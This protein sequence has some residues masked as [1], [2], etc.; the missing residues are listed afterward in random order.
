MQLGFKFCYDKIE[1]MHMTRRIGMEEFYSIAA[2]VDKTDYSE[3]AFAPETLGRIMHPLCITI[4]VPPKADN[5]LKL[6]AAA[7]FH[8]TSSSESILLAL[9]KVLNMQTSMDCNEFIQHA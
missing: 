9:S 3:I 5:A 6:V 4:E 1:I 7:S 2:V 8:A